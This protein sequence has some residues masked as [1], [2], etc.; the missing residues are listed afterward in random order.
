ME[1]TEKTE[2]LGKLTA[3]AERIHIRNILNKPLLSFSELDLF[4]KSK[5]VILTKSIRT[6]K[7]ELGD[8][9]IIQQSYILFV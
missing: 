7:N 2:I 6:P 8:F 9:S 3:T 4:L 5:A 1:Q